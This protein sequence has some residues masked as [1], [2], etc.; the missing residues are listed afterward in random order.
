MKNAIYTCLWCGFMVF[1]EVF[2]CY[3]ICPICD[4][5]DDSC[6]LDDPFIKYYESDIPLIERQKKA[7]VQYPLGA[8]E[9]IVGNITLIRN[10]E[11]NPINE[12]VFTKN[13]PFFPVWKYK[14][15]IERYW[16]NKVYADLFTIAQENNPDDVIFW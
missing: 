16:E 1:H 2:S 13:Q 11:W 9:A 8:K 12:I 4:F 5:Q 10:K 15:F 6:V 14:E 7:M 3:E